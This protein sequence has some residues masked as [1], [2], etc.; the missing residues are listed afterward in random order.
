VLSKP[1]G[2]LIAKGTGQATIGADPALPTVSVSDATAVN[3]PAGT[4]KGYAEFTVTLSK[5]FAKKVALRFKTMPGTATK[6]TDYTTSSVTV[7]FN[8]GETSKIVKVRILK[9]TITEPAEQFTVVLS[10]PVR[11]VINDGTGVGTINAS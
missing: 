6:S 8:P 7:T 1:V 3:E 5:S 10:T 2:A 9:D 4:S 11:C